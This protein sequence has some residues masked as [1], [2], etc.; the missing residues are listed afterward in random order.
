M[1]ENLEKDTPTREEYIAYMN[2][3][4]ELTKI[5]VELQ[6]LQTKIAVARAEEMRALAFLAQIQGQ[7]KPDAEDTEDN[8]EAEPS[9]EKP[10]RKLSK[11][12]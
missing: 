10:A 3:T 12:N 9:G 1:P 11:N 7:G 2:E 5:R 4:I 8:N 6:E